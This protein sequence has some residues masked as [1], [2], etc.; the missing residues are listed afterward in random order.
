LNSGL[1]DGLKTEAELTS[2]LKQLHSTA[3]EAMLQGELDSH[4]GYPKNGKSTN[5]NKHHGTTKKHIKT[6]LQKKHI[7]KKL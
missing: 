1:L 2:L 6:E 3:L 4:L 7:L 5:D